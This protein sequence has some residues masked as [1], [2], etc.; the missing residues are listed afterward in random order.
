MLLNNQPYKES[1]SNSFITI[2]ESSSTQNQFLTYI[3]THSDI[4]T[5]TVLKNILL[6]LKRKKKTGLRIYY[7]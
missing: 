2:V 5:C 7:Y 3:S 6:K 4:H 1:M